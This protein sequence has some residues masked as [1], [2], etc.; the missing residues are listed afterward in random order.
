MRLGSGLLSNTAFFASRLPEPA[1]AFQSLRLRRLI[2]HQKTPQPLCY[3]FTFA[4][5][6][7][8]EGR[9]SIVIENARLVAIDAE[10]ILFLPVGEDALRAHLFEIRD[11]FS[12][13]ALSLEI[14]EGHA[15]AA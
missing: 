2:M 8:L 15:A 10:G 13:A 3:P 4:K 6:T 11:Q 5:P 14:H 1:R 7:Q 12:G 9:A